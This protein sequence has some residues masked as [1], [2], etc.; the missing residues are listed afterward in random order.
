MYNDCIWEI[1]GA[2]KISRA[3]GFNRSIFEHIVSIENL[4]SAWKKFKRGKTKKRDVIEFA[5]NLE[6]NIF[7]LRGELILGKWICGG[8]VKFSIKDPKSRIIHKA[9]V[10]DRVLYQAIY[11]VLY[12]IFD[13]TFIFDVYSSRKK[14]YSCRN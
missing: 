8:Y 2:T 3:G 11:R 6:D 14:G 4:F 5:L 1:T 13:K 10:R 12:P 9:T 7:A